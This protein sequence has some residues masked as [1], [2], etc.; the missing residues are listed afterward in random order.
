[1]SN[2]HISDSNPYSGVEFELLN[3]SMG[4]NI[5]HV[6]PYMVMLHINRSLHHWC[7]F[8]QQVVHSL[9]RLW[10]LMIIFLI[11]E[12]NAM[13]S[14]GG[15]DI[16][17]STSGGTSSVTT[18]V[19]AVVVSLLNLLFLLIVGVTCAR[20]IRAKRDAK[21]SKIPYKQ[22]QSNGAFRSE[23]GTMRSFN[24]LTS[25]FTPTDF[26]ADS[27]SSLSTIS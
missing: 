5:I 24:S 6:G 7:H 4:F 10:H 8:L 27:V 23:A 22:G 25:K 20:R 19:V 14:L 11:S 1:M 9:K 16:V 12:P 3:F 18:T 2:Q 17:A 15:A 21:K 13:A 26:D